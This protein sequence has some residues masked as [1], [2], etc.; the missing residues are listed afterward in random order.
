MIMNEVFKQR[1]FRLMLAALRRI[2]CNA[3]RFYMTLE[4]YLMLGAY[5][6]T[7]IFSF[8]QFIYKA[9]GLPH[10]IS[11]NELGLIPTMFVHNPTYGGS[12][13]PSDYGKVF[14]SLL[15]MNTWIGTA[16]GK[17]LLA[18]DGND[19]YQLNIHVDLND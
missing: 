4:G 3:L 16:S 10:N 2:N 9:N 11:F 7:D 15:A 19:I 1:K 8:D 18:G 17:T 13:D 12:V 14:D 5:S 6:S